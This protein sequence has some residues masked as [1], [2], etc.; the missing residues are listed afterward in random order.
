MEAHIAANW[1]G[2]IVKIY[3]YFQDSTQIL[4]ITKDEYDKLKNDKL[5]LELKNKV[6]VFYFKKL[7]PYVL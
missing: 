2:K 7:R 4:M 1:S 5:Q 3:N 6:D